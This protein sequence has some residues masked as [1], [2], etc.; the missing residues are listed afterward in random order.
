MRNAREFQNE[1][2]REYTLAHTANAA[3]S[4]SGWPQSAVAACASGKLAVM[5]WK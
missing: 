5:V 3:S 2:T 1:C 4:E